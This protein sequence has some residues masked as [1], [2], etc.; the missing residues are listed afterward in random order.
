MEALVRLEPAYI[1][2]DTYSG[3]PEDLPDTE[4]AQR[5]LDVLVDRVLDLNGA[6]LR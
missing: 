1:V 3:R 5:T 6:T 2:L 4:V